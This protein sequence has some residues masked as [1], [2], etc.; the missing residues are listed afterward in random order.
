MAD[1]VSNY[2]GAEIDAAVG[3]YLTGNTRS[4]IVVSVQEDKWKDRP[5]TIQ[6][7][8]KYYIRIQC[9]GSSYIGHMPEC[10]LI[11][12]PVGERIT[13]SLLY[14]AEGA[15]DGVTDIFIG[16]NTKFSCDVVLIGSSPISP[17][18]GTVV[19]NPT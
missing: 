10:F 15:S 14:F 18:S 2:T 7:D 16:S 9:T 6:L 1:Y 5:N 11:T 12:T 13:P 17:V 19:V 8:G 3:A 4:T